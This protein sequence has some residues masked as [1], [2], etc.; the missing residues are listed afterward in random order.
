M[1][2]KRG[3]TGVSQNVREKKRKRVSG[4]VHWPL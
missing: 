1:K 2:M 4:W 3:K